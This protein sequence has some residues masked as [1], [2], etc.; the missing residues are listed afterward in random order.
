M[1]VVL[2]KNWYACCEHC[3][4]GGSRSGHPDPC[5]KGCDPLTGN[6]RVA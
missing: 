6:P 1:T 4:H 2:G 5:E 3:K